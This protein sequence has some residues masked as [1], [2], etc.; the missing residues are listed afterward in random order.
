MKRSLR[1]ATILIALGLM[2]GWAIGGSAQRTGGYKEIAADDPEVAAAAEFA[3]KAQGE[4][5]DIKIK[6]LSV[7]HAESQVVAGINYRL[8]LKV[9]VET[10]DKD[11]D[12]TQT[13]RTV[14]YRSLQKEYSLTS[15]ADEECGGD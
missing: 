10:E 12:A 5:Q 4:K 9:E 13:V 6:L 3:C 7:E 11:N 15:W 2:V 1:I 8:C 14:V